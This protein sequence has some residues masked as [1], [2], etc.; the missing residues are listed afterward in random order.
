MQEIPP[1]NATSEGAGFGLGT[2]DQA[3]PFHDSINVWKSEAAA[4]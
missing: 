3:D 1:K 4:W 2:T